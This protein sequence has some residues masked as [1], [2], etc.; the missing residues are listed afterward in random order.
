[1]PKKVIGTQDLI[2]IK[3]KAIYLEDST[4]NE[5]DQHAQTDILIK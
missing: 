2:L 3:N 5:G 4:P 1:M